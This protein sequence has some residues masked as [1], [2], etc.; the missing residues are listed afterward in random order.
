M[1]K[2]Y[3][4]AQ[5]G[6]PNRSCFYGHLRASIAVG[7][8]VFQCGPQTPSYQV[9]FSNGMEAQESSEVANVLQQMQ[10]DY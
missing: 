9:L 7:G 4:P 3:F 10:I 2:Q 5:P 1:Q 6:L 8:Y